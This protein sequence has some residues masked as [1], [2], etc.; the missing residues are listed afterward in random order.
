MF[1]VAPLRTLFGDPSEFGQIGELLMTT[2]A[3][4]EAEA[5]AL[6][7]VETAELEFLMT[8]GALSEA[9]S[10]EL[11]LLIATGA[12]SEAETSVLEEPS[13]LLKIFEHCLCFFAEIFFAVV[14]DRLHTSVARNL[15][16]IMSFNPT[17]TQFLNTSFTS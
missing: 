13:V 4:S 3:L 14:I 7:E 10:A 5:G 15:H 11:E 1:N 17:V 9:E 2:G 6:S 16:D 12:L 8:T